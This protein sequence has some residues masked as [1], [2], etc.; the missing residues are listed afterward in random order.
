VSNNDAPDDEPPNEQA[1]LT[2]IRFVG[3]ATAAVLAGAPFDASGI[4]D[5]TVSYEMLVEAGVNPG[6][7]TRLRREHSLP[8]SFA[9]DEESLDERSTK[10]R[11]LQDGEREWVAASSGDWESA[12]PASGGASAEASADGSGAA[13]AAEAAWRDRSK[14]DPATDVPGVDEA[15][16]DLL[17]E[18]GVTSVRSLA[19]ADP[20]H[21]ADSLELD[22]ERVAA[23][24]D[25]ARD[26]A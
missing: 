13:E 12:E 5:K 23:W 3:P 17:A 15:V 18:A 16:A 4:P 9:G 2:D 6:V 22:R 8:W 24:R 19:T 20:E 11:G 1:D 10:V 26:L 14:P 25:A 7:A 21:V